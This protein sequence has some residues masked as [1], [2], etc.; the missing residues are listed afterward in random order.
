MKIVKTILFLVIPVILFPGCTKSGN[1]KTLDVPA[2][3]FSTGPAQVNTLAGLPVS[4]SSAITAPALIPVSIPATTATPVVPMV[5]APSPT[6]PALNNIADDALKQKMVKGETDFILVDARD[7]ASWDNGH[8]QYSIL[9]EPGT[10]G[11]NQSPE[12]VI[13]QLEMLPP[14]SLAILYDDGFGI[15]AIAL[16]EKLI[17][18]NDGYDINNVMVLTGG[19]FE[20]SKSGYPIEKDGQ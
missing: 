17:N 7:K 5:P 1:T 4:S 3:A 19:Y 8:L 13:I 20:W 9:I 14:K 18:L 2:V 11:A 15:D 6:L 10:S 16:A 12:N